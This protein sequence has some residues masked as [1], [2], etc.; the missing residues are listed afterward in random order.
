MLYPRLQR[1]YA[2]FTR[3]PAHQTP[4]AR[5]RFEPPN[6]PDYVA[7]ILPFVNTQEGGKV[8]LRRTSPTQRAPPCM[9][10]SSAFFERL[11]SRCLLIRTHTY[12]YVLVR[13]HTFPYLPILAHT[14]PHLPMLSYSFFYFFKRSHPKCSH[15][16]SY[17][18]I[19]SHTYSYVLIRRSGGFP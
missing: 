19:R 8:L 12:S 3:N 4:C 15:T 17:V 16:S 1:G 6:K 2:P 11:N 10:L 7:R 9:T 13:S 14:Y 18:I 5:G